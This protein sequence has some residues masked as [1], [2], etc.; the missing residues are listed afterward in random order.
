MTLLETRDDV[1]QGLQ[2]LQLEWHHTLANYLRSTGITL[3]MN[4]EDVQDSRGDTKMFSMQGLLPTSYYY[5]DTGWFFPQDAVSGSE[6]AEARL[7]VTHMTANNFY[8]LYDTGAIPKKSTEI[9]ALQVLLRWRLQEL[10]KNH[11]LD[12]SQSQSVE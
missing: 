3:N 4:V 5:L 10:I 7:V 12:E 11:I 9:E 1:F 8:D 6:F 2:D